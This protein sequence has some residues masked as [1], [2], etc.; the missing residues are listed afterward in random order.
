[1]FENNRVFCYN[2]SMEN[3]VNILDKQG[4]TLLKVKNDRILVA[5]FPDMSEAMKDLVVYYYTE[6][7][8]RDS[9]RIKDYLDFTNDDQEFC[10]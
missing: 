4:R 10:S 1:M 3:K 7:G 2:I 9:A 5:R 8:G 6:L